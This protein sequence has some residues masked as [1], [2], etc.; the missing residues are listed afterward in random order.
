MTQYI[1]IFVA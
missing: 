1:Q